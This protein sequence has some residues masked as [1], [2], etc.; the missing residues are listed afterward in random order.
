MEFFG[1]GALIFMKFS[2]VYPYFTQV[3]RGECN[4]ILKSSR[5]SVNQG[6]YRFWDLKF[7]AFARLFQNN[8]FFFQIQGYQ[9]GGQ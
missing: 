9:I 5:V 7:T 3:L 2:G 8:N 4:L 1:G 6:S